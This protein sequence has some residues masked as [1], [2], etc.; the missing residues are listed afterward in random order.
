MQRLKNTQEC[1]VVKAGVGSRNKPEAK[2]KPRLRGEGAPAKCRRYEGTATLRLFAIFGKPGFSRWSRLCQHKQLSLHFFEVYVYNS[3]ITCKFERKFGV[4]VALGSF[5]FLQS[6]Q[7]P[8]SVRGI[9][10]TSSTSCL[11]SEGKRPL[12]L[13]FGPSSDLAK[14]S[15]FFCRC[16]L[17]HFESNMAQV[18][19]SAKV[20]YK[21]WV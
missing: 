12:V 15:S 8:P 16:P 14:Y 18:F 5:L 19:S 1:H 6:V 7:D 3:G 13:R 10:D 11:I 21:R 4:N 9:Y 20:S 2:R 17:S